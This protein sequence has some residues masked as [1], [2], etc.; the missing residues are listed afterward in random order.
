M[1]WTQT[2]PQFEWDS[3]KARENA[4]KHRISFRH[5][6]AIWQRTLVIEV[7]DRYD[8][9]EVR[10]KAI[11]LLPNLTC[12]VV[13]YVERQQVIRII[14]ARLADSGETQSYYEQYGYNPSTK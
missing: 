2:I 10:F 4:R 14:S 9:D 6:K 12:I 11:G 13:I 8:Y 5:A 3:D 1:T 7:D